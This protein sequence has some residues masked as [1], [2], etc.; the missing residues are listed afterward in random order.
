MI[1]GVQYEEELYAERLRRTTQDARLAAGTTQ[2]TD[3]LN[4]GVRIKLNLAWNDLIEHVAFRTYWD[5]LD[6][7][8]AHRTLRSIGVTVRPSDM[9]PGTSR[10]TNEQLLSLLEVEHEALKEVSAQAAAAPPYPGAQPPWV[11]KPL[12]APEDF[13][14]QVNQVLEAHIVAFY[15]HDNSRLVEVESHEMHDAVV[16]PT[17]YLLHSQPRF[18]AAETAY[19]NALAEIRRRDPGDAVTDAATALQE[20]LTALGCTGGAL[21]DLLKSAKNKGLVKG[22][23]TPL[24]EAIGKTVDWVAA[25]RNQGEAHKGDPDINMSDAWM[26]VHVV[27]ALIIRLAEQNGVQ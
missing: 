24:T 21:G 16:A 3:K 22:N 13:R 10:V 8:I 4:D 19:Q 6:E 7:Y 2:W 17:L 23:D 15:L 14:S 26:M 9:E 5:Q 20:A 27:G 11:Q 25:K 18:A 12:T 1:A